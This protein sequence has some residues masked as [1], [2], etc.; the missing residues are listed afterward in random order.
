MSQ[1]RQLDL[2]SY[3]LM[4]VLGRTSDMLAVNFTH[5]NELIKTHVQVSNEGILST[6]TSKTHHKSL[7]VFWK[8]M[9]WAYCCKE[10]STAT[11]LGTYAL[12]A[13]PNT[14]AHM[15]FLVGAITDAV[16]FITRNLVHVLKMLCQTND[17]NYGTRWSNVS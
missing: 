3:Q 10:S 6:R 15:K 7:S 16:D 9:P 8:G 12:S 2:S 5:P 4:T 14:L 17:V 1:N 13:I 11:C